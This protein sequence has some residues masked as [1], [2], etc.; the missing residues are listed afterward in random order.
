MVICLPRG[1][2][3]N[4]IRALRGYFL[5]YYHLEDDIVLR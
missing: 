5:I 1:G 2:P 3:R 4:V